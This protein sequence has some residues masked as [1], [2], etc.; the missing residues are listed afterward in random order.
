MLDKLRSM[1]VFAKVVELGSFRRAA[2]ALDLSA[3]VVS[4]HVATLEK[5]IGVTLLYRS[6][7]HLSP[8]PDGARLYESCLAMVQSAEAGLSAM[9]SE[10]AAL[11]G[12]LWFIA[13]GPFASPRFLAS[14]ADFA[15]LHPQL[16][17]RVDFDDR[18]RNIVQEGIDLAIRFGEQPDSSLV[19]RKLFDAPRRIF[20]SPDYLARCGEPQHPADLAQHE[21]VSIGAEQSVDMASANELY[22]AVPIRARMIVSNG[23]VQRQLGCEGLGLIL[24]PAFIVQEELQQGLLREV[25]PGWESAGAGCYALFPARVGANSASRRFVDFLMERILQASEIKAAGRRSD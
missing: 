2:E 6:T 20:A 13:P 23:V 18:P 4:H 19:S 25:L 5:Q 11:N 22:K 17:I 3:S 10:S 21:W 8:T 15:R 24:L 12:R 7:R 14:V 16:Q 9:A 1:A